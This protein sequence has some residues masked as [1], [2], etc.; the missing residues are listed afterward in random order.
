MVRRM[1]P[2]SVVVD[3][4]AETGGNVEL[5]EPGKDV[6]V[7]GVTIVGTKNVPSTV[8]VHASQLYSRNVTNLLMHLLKDGKVALDFE[9]EITRETC[10]T[11][12]GKIV[13]E[14]AQKMMEPEKE[15]RVS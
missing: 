15:E 10:V 8:P 11:H 7:G 6:D 9:D 5:T 3:L 1:R 13:N 12:A 2:G 14:R 4:A